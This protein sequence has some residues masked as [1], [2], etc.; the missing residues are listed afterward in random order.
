MKKLLKALLIFSMISCLPLQAWGPMTHIEVNF[1]AYKIVGNELKGAFGIPPAFA[2]SFIGCGP[3]PD[4]NQMGGKAFPK[5]FHNDPETVLRMVELAKKDPRFGTLDVVEALGWAGHLYAEVFSNHRPDGYANSKVTVPL[6]N[7]GYLNHQLAELCVDIVTYDEFRSEL[8]PLTMSVPMRLLD[9]AP[10]AEN[11][12]NSQS[13]AIS[14][15]QIKEATNAFLPTVAGIKT[16][17]EFLRKERPELVEEMKTFYSDRNA[18]VETSVKDVSQMLR[19]NAQNDFKKGTEKSADGSEKISLALTGSFM[20]KVKKIGLNAFYRALRAGAANDIFTTFASGVINGAVST[21]LTRD[22]F[23]SFASRF[24]GGSASGEVHRKVLSRFQE[25]L[26]GK[27]ELTFPEI[28]A[29][30]MEGFE[31][32]PKISETRKK[33]FSAL[34]LREDGRAPVDPG[35]LMEA[36]AEVE[37]MEDVRRGWPWFWPW[38]PSDTAMALAREK[39]GRLLAFHFLDN[40]TTPGLK[41]RA[42]KLLQDDRILREKI[43]KYKNQT[44]LN[45]FAKYD[46]HKLMQKTSDAFSP[47]QKFLAETLKVINMTGTTKPDLQKLDEMIVQTREKIEDAEMVLANSRNGFKNIP[48]YNLIKRQELKED[49]KRQEMILSDMK[50]SLSTL[51]EIKSQYTGSGVAAIQSANTPTT[52]LSRSEIQAKYE[53]AYSAYVKVLGEKG[54]DDP[55]VKEAIRSFREIERLRSDLIKAGPR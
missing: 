6:A 39:A 41:A 46:L 40:V 8:K 34:K 55:A 16:V 19:E 21:N 52:K 27:P 23:L 17:A 9:A 14:A 20:E 1:Q 32:D 15:S 2:N 13:P 54:P 31:P 11:S 22:K 35:K 10:K 30:S 12:R 5:A 18:A 28:I 29:Y 3:S 42:Q 7:S 36:I 53:K 43:W 47:D 25:A 38:R 37:R 48:F 24:G 51:S 26:L 45:P 33:Q 49:I 44:F 4:I 50:A